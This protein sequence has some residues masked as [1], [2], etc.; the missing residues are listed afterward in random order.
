MGSTYGSRD[1]ELL[2]DELDVVV[3]VLNS[4]LEVRD[5]RPKVW[6]LGAIVAD[7]SNGCDDDVIFLL[8]I[9]S[10]LEPDLSTGIP[11]DLERREIQD[12]AI[13]TGRTGVGERERV[14]LHTSLKK[15]MKTKKK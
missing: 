1:I 15:S 11:V 3:A 2:I 4:L 9:R 8:V 13:L 5:I 12:L 10:P 14:P 7:R 6:I